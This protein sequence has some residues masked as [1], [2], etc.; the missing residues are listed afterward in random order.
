MQYNPHQ[1]GS[2][3]SQEEPGGYCRETCNIPFRFQIPPLFSC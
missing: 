2:L 3:N 1:A